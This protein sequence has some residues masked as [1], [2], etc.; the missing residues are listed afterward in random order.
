[1]TPE[2]KI[3]KAKEKLRKK[4]GAVQRVL[5]TDDGQTLL[6]ALREEFLYSVREESPHGS[7]Y[8][9]GTA[10]VVGYLMQLNDF[11]EE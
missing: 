1:M 5:A 2:Q 8:R 9:V 11:K 4:A 7:G 10:D 3:A 6:R